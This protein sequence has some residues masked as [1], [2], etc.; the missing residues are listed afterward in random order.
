MARNPRSSKKIVGSR[1]MELNRCPA[2]RVQA[3]HQE[4]VGSGKL[5]PKQFND[6]V[7]S[8]GPIPVELIRAGL[9]GLPLTRET[10]AA[11]RFAE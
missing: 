6:A 10:R 2:G 5:T 8:Y 3:L 7:L 1:E 4:L 9:L 11:W